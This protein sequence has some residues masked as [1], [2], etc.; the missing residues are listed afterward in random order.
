MPSPT[1]CTTPLATVQMLV[2]F[3]ATDVVPS[4]L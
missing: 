3:E 2:E 4:P 1:K